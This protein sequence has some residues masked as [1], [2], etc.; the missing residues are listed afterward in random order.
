MQ[1]I[2][3]ARKLI[4]RCEEEIHELIAE[5]LA[6]R[7]YSDIEEL[8]TLAEGLSALARNSNADLSI[9]TPTAQPAPPRSIRANAHS[10]RQPGATRYPCFERQG[11]RL[12][13]IGWSQKDRTVYEHRAPKSAV[14]SITS[15]LMSLQRKDRNIRIDDLLPV[16]SEDGVEIPTYQVYLVLAWLRT[17]G[18]IQRHGNE[19][20]QSLRAFRESEFASIWKQ[21]KER[22]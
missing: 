6:A 15:K 21:T 10:S 8:A 2:A 5:A 18:M 16:E 11:D 19:G 20:Y 4:S 7:D 14:D 9:S 3:S 1:R 13:K 22:N 17:L 12:I